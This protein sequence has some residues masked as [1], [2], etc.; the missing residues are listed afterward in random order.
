M[1]KLEP[2][3]LAIS[4]AT[5]QTVRVISISP[6]GNWFAGVANP[7]MPPN[8]QYFWHEWS[9]ASFTVKH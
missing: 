6:C 8:F 9:L 7:D 3:R 4:K 1:S 2:G 5:R